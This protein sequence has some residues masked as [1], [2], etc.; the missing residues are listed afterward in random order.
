MVQK[1]EGGLQPA[2]QTGIQTGTTGPTGRPGEKHT[3]TQTTRSTTDGH[4]DTPRETNG[5]AHVTHRRFDSSVFHVFPAP[6]TNFNPRLS[7]AS[8]GIEVDVEISTD[9]GFITR[10][11]QRSIQLRCSIRLGVGRERTLFE[12]FTCITINISAIYFY[13]IAIFFKSHCRD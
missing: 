3:D 11:R 8:Y 7:S 6:R 13:Y 9:G 4:G 10:G 12:R 1:C 2:A 5:G